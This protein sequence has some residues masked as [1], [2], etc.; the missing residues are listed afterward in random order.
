MNALGGDSG[1]QERLLAALSVHVSH[2][3]RNPSMFTKLE[4]VVI[5]E[6][7]ERTRL[8]RSKL[9]IWS[10]GCAYGEEPYSV[11][12]LCENLQAGKPRVSII[13]TDVSAEA[14]RT[15]RQGLFPQGRLENVSR[16]LS[17]EFFIP[18]QGNRRL[19]TKIREQVQFFRHDI[20]TDAPFYRAELILCRNLLI[21][22]S[23]RQQI[24]IL[25]KLAG[26]LLPGGYLILG[27]AETLAPSCRA[28]FHCVDPA[29]RIY[30][31][32]AAGDGGDIIK[33]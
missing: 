4:K 24:E 25:E 23:R 16:S 13:A 33:V 18:E 32:I 3:F 22:F 17:E 27:R 19:V 15:A 11:A 7:L 5:P 21:Y 2:F 30:Q 10:V 12:L 6:L 20:L 29:E 31:R 9:R 26:A 14:L 8:E 28:F 1:E